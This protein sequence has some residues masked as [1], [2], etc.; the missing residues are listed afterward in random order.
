MKKQIAII[1]GTRPNFIKVTQFK[2]IAELAG[3]LQITIIHTGQH[4]D[5]KMADVF[6]R[7][8][9]L[10]PDVFLNIPQGSPANQIGNIVLKLEEYFSN[11]TPDLVIV[12]G[13]VNSTLAAAI[14]ANKM[15]LKIAHLESG[16]RSFDHSMPEEINRILTDKI[17][18]I[19]FVT[20][21][22][23]IKNLSE[24]GITENVFFVGNTMIDTMVS[25]EK[26]ID[27]SDV[28]N[29]L[30][31]ERNDQFVLMTLHRPSNVDHK[32]GLKKLVELINQLTKDYIVVFPVHP[33]TL[34]NLS[35]FDLLT[36]IENTNRLKFT[37]PLDY[38]SFQNLIKN[39]SFIIT[40]SGGIQEESTFRRVPCI[41]LRENT[42]RPVT[43]EV[44]SNVLVEFEI[45]KIAAVINLIQSGKF[46]TSGIPELW[47]G[48]STERIIKILKEIL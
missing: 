21:P 10:Q 20:E 32:Q 40:D 24:E 18:D 46:K 17:S 9:N 39:A 23:G 19:F 34:K 43:I 8:L 12:V 31:I 35:G 14:C 4:H 45:E 15:N 37:Q 11:A 25:F 47:D 3:G 33:R 41:T 27:S 22:S 6:F 36:S 26:E 2:K 5:E 28:L 29:E 42:E 38:F 44:G 13:D 16:L 30:K 7:Q 48:K 1:V